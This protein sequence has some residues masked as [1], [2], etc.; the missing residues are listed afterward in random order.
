[1][2][3]PKEEKRL[4][5]HVLTQ[6]EVEAGARP[7]HISRPADYACAILEL[8]Y[9]S[10]LRRKEVLG[11]MHSDIDRERHLILGAR[12]R[13]Q[14]S[15][16]TVGRAPSRQFLFA[17]SRQIGYNTPSYLA[18]QSHLAPP[19]RDTVLEGVRTVHDAQNTLYVEGNP[20]Q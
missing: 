19:A 11:L 6:E 18:S 5:R 1:M 16:R 2:V 13:Q 3:F 12:K 8:L 15:L 20:P 7:A 17:T 4:P 10:G 9:S 14:G